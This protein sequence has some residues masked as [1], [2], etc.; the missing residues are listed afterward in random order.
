MS[1]SQSHDSLPLRKNPHPV[2][3]ATA[4]RDRGG[5]TV[6]EV[7]EKHGSPKASR[8][9]EDKRFSGAEKQNYENSPG[10]KSSDVNE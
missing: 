1:K 3:P 9:T 10:R 6:P 8:I 7:G 2:T 5:N 4:R